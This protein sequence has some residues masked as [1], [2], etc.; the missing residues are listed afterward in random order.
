MK[1]TVDISGFGGRYEAACQIMLQRGIDWIA[2]H[3][4]FNIGKSYKQF[5]GVTGICFSDE[6][7]AKELDKCINS[8]IEPSGAMHHAVIS[9]LARIQSVGHE[10]WIAEAKAANREV[11]EIDL[12]E[13][14]KTFSA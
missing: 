11:Y 12:D 1:E 4:D 5:K 2:S 3:P 6:E 9:H 10:Q 8:G 14:R 7:K 13:T